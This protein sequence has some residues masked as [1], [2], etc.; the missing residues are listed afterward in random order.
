M[1][2]LIQ[3]THGAPDVLELQ[4]RLARVTGLL[5]LVIAVLGM[6]AP[7]ALQT[8]VVPGDAATSAANILGSRWLFSSSLVTWVV[9]VVADAA[10]AVTL[11]LLLE[12]VSRALSLVAAALRLVYAAIL[13]A[14]VLN[15]Y[16]A[17]LLLT[18]AARGAGLDLQQ[19]QTMAL[20]SLATFSAGFLLALVFFGVHLVALGFLL[21][22]S[23][24]VPRAFGVLLVAAGGGYIVDSLAHFF[25]ADYGGLA[26]AILLAPAVVGELGLTAWLLVKGVTV[27][28]DVAIDSHLAGATGGTRRR[29]VSSEPPKS[30]TGSR[31]K[32][33]GGA[34]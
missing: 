18:S 33:R 10:V 17:F 16:D 2:A 6:F 25:V 31:D 21:Y 23:R 3:H 28:R 26:R 1:K 24:Y 29:F 15:L 11:Y 14:V 19:R 22:R 30:E 4:E 7:I 12:P 5:Y 20:S 13:G 8:L 27:R 34:S 9:L 32:A